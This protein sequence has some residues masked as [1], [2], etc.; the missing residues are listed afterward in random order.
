MCVGSQKKNE[1]K[2]M[3]CE[4]GIPHLL[5]PCEIIN[6]SQRALRPPPYDLFVYVHSRRLLW[7]KPMKGF[8]SEPCC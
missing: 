1:V 2:M 3:K 5:N 4:M 7:L 8:G 6:L